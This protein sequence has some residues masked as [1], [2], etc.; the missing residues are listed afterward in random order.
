[1]AYVRFKMERNTW[2]L[3]L[4]NDSIPRLDNIR[5]GTLSTIIDTPYETIEQHT[6][7]V[8]IEDLTHQVLDNRNSTIGSD[9]ESLE[10]IGRW[11]E[12][13][14]NEYLHAKYQDKIQLNEIEIIWLNEKFEQGKPYDFI[15]KY[16][17][18]KIITYIE[19]KSTLSNN[20]QLIPITYNEL[21]YCC[22]LSDINQHFQ[23]YR[24]YNTG[25]VKKVKLRIVENLEEKLR[26]HDLELF[27]LI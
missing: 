8:N 17:K 9:Q 12:Q 6:K 1:M 13:W 18:T 27:L 7:H 20:R 19:V 4:V 21:Q 24:V 5:S 10:K 16:L 25:Q 2:G 23:I 26:K 11:G 3:S 22:S 15:I 14:V